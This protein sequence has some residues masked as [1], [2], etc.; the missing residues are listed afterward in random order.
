MR[1]ALR[2][3]HSVSFSTESELV[4]ALWGL[5]HDVDRISEADVGWAETVRRCRRA[6]VFVWVSTRS[7]AHRW[8]QG[9]AAAA[10]EELN[11]SLPTLA[12]HL[13]RFWGLHANDRE[14]QIHVEPWFRLGLVCTADGGRDDAWR[15]VGVNHRWFPPAV[16]VFDCGWGT[17]RHEYR[18]DVA[19]VGSWQSYGHPEWHHRAALVRWLRQ[20]YGRRLKLWPVSGQ[21]AVRGEALA[22]LYASVDVAV[23]DS[24]LVPTNGRPA[25]HY[26]SDRVPETLGRG[27]L[28]VH[29][30]VKG[31]TDGTLWTDG[32]HLLCWELEDWDTLGERIDWALSHPDERAE[33]A[34][35]GRVHTLENHT[36]TRRMADLLAELEAT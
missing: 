2:G 8:P 15:A 5:G 28:L 7:N 20:H 18:S 26:C 17:P 24:C 34:A 33:I 35:A 1:L 32:E 19:F 14:A 27:A 11:R 22:D 23:G 21:P 36:Y 9:E 13:D 25:T 6:D 12:I 4:K 16:S 30:A 31:V 3:N 29:P 10:V